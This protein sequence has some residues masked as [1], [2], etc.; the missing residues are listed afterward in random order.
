MTKAIQV[1]VQFAAKLDDAP[2]E[3]EVRAWVERVIDRVGGA[4][5]RPIEIS[6]RIVGEAEGLA[7]NRRYRNRDH[8]TNVL[9]FPACEEGLNDPPG[10]LPLALGDIVICGP[11]AAREATDQGKKHSDH[12]AQLIVHG[13][14]HLFGYDHETDSEARQMET[15]EADILALGGV[16][17]LYESKD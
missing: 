7:L 1:D 6:V 3:S 17:N 16:E 4:A 13:A 9:S 15:L 2:A 11:V 5:E 10:D 8:A 12:W 14:L